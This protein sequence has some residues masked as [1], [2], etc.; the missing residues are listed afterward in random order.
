M[1]ERNTR[2]RLLRRA[3]RASVVIPDSLAD[4][5]A[6]YLDLLFRWNRKINLT[7]LTEL[8]EAID[9]LLLEPL[10]AARHFPTGAGQLIDVGSG[11]GSPAIPLALALSEYRVTLIESKA[12][13]AAFLREVI[14]LLGLDR[15]TV[16]PARFQALL[17]ESAHL[18]RYSAFSV[19][20]VRL[21]GQALTELSGFLAPGGIGAIF[22]GPQGPDRGVGAPPLT[23]AG[24]YPLLASL[25][26]RLTVYR[27]RI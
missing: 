27:L 24:T 6:V 8:D 5:L 17:G 15:A 9:R 3:A 21:E 7:G 18:R 2:T 25:G 22:R 1:A 16:E 23:W 4:G 13:K 14:R 11:G 10:I 20:A 12:R 19:R 26:S